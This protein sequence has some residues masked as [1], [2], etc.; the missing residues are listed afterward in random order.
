[1]LATFLSHK[2]RQASMMIAGLLVFL[3][4]VL[5]EHARALAANVADDGCLLLSGL[6][7]RQIDEEKMEV[8]T[9]ATIAFRSLFL[10]LKS[11]FLNTLWFQLGS[12]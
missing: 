4:P 11:L 6:L 12:K 8:E 5:I 2:I 1:M 3:A 9:Q 10:A 7:T